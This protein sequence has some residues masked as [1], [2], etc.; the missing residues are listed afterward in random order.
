MIFRK[1]SIIAF[2]LIL[3]L[4]VINPLVIIK[5]KDNDEVD[6]EYIK[7]TYGKGL[8]EPEFSAEQ[9]I[10]GEFNSFKRAAMDDAAFN[11]DLSDEQRKELMS[12]LKTMKFKNR[13]M[14][15]FKMITV[16]PVLPDDLKFTVKFLN[17]K[18]ESISIFDY[19]QGFKV[20]TTGYFGATYVTYQYYWII[21]ADRQLVKSNFQED[22]LPLRMIVEFPN[23]Q[24]RIYLAKI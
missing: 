5:D 3:S 8:K 2:L 24:K 4:S 6:K 15:F 22:E 10:E 13:K 16:E 14:V 19:Y 7:E 1:I 11:R 17:G 18:D 9:M 23:G 21:E 20:I 12:K